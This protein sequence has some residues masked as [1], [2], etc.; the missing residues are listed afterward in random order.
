MCCQKRFLYWLQKPGE[1]SCREGRCVRTDLSISHGELHKFCKGRPAASS[2]TG[3][4]HDSSHHSSV[5]HVSASS[6]EAVGMGCQGSF[7]NKLAATVPKFQTNN[8][9]LFSQ[10]KISGGS[11]LHV[12]TLFISVTSCCEW[13]SLVDAGVSHPCDAKE[14]RGCLSP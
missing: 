13:V 7:I 2:L 6:S 4:W 8:C 11:S 5:L 14:L 10:L 3:R 1:F 9:T 12:F